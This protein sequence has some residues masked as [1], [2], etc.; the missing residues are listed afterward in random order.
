MC[1]YSRANVF[2]C[3]NVAIS[4]L[5]RSDVLR[6]NVRCPFSCL[7]IHSCRKHCLMVLH[8]SVGQLLLAPTP[9]II[10]VPATFFK[11]KRSFCLPDDVWLVDLDSNSVIKPPGVEDLPPLPEPEGSHLLYHLKQVGFSF[12]RLPTSLA[13][14]FAFLCCLCASECP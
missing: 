13:D 4:E 10:G 8:G 12:N 7:D 9:Y 1:S 5:H 14:L 6:W 3:F 2:A 11:L